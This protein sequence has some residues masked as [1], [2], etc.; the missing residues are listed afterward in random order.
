MLSDALF[1]LLLSSVGAVVL[2]E[3]IGYFWH[4]FAEHRGW[5]GDTV[6]YR[7]WVHHELDYPVD[8]LRP[9]GVK[10][11]RKAGSW[12]WFVVGAAAV[13]LML[14]L[15]PL[16][17]GLPLALGVVLYSWG[18][19]S[20]LHNRFHVEGHWLE[21]FAWFRRIRR[22]HDIHHWQ[23]GN[24]GILFFWMDRLFGTLR[25]DFPPKRVNIFPGYRSAR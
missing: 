12:T 22:L 18:V 17:Q 15:L 9:V 23:P 10:N 16:D 21:R 19:I 2:V 8:R 5:L 3:A 11:Y 4:R 20:Y 14:Y 25:E 7:H 1:A 6:R 13:A 24:Y